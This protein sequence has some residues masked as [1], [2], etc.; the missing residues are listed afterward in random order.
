MKKIK[1]KYQRQVNEA[2][3]ACKESIIRN[4]VDV[5]KDYL[6][7]NE[8]DHIEVQLTNPV[9]FHSQEK[10][11]KRIS[12]TPQ[13]AECIVIAGLNSDRRHMLAVAEGKDTYCPLEWMPIS[14]LYHVFME[15]LDT[16]RNTESEK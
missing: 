2:M 12:Y 10:H 11:K 4:I 1:S 16:V 5:I 6:E 13:I 9:F 8:D 3:H 7:K 14:S 15:V